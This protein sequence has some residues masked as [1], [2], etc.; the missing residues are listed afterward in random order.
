MIAAYYFRRIMRNIIVFFI[1]I[2]ELF[3]S[4]TPFDL[5]KKEGE[6][7]G[8]TLLIIG[9]IHGDEPGGYFA[10]AFLE[11]YYKIK[12]GNLW[13]IPNLN[14]DSIMANNRGIYGD[15]NR[16]FSSVDKNDNDFIS[17]NKVK[18]IILD[19]NVDLIL[20][21]HDGHGFYRDK[22]E[23]AIFNPNAW[24][25]ATIIDQEKINGLEKFGNLDEIANKVT[26]I[27]NN[28]NLFQ[29]YHS[30]GVKNTQTKY[31]DEQMQLSLTYFAV[32]NNKPA[33]AI[34]TSKNITELTYKVI[35]QLK[36]IEEFMK[37]MDIKF[38]RD[39]DINNYEEVKNKIYDFG[40]VT[41]N[42]N[43][44]FDLTDIKSNM[45]FVPLK[46]DDNKFDFTHSL[47]RVKNIDNNKYE[48]YI[49]NI[50]VCDLYPQIFDLSSSKEKIKI[51]VDGK[52]IE[53]SFANTVDIKNDFKILK[54]D[55][56]VNIIGFNKNGVDSEDDILI[57]KSD[58]QDNYS[59]DNSNNKYR[60]EFYKNGKFYGMIIL[61]FSGDKNE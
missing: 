48:L 49:G 25:Q 7:K 39:F 2:V 45:R 57:K 5:Y 59:I 18:K 28:D 33:L 37:I 52:Q 36:S 43:I 60:V 38:E 41:I 51:L 24:G 23:N 1:F 55:F 53:T 21:L 3:A 54:S 11:K 26:S 47:A 42:N 46:K 27:L 16:K 20:N 17:I 4:N 14:V 19:N 8:H 50:K 22:Y 9:G 58:I 10:P 35:Y 34:E 15:M 32:T 40:K 30:F 12:S 31:K 56:R 44:S 29:E 61:N 6:I 13:I